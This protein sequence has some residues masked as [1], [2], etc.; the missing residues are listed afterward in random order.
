MECPKCTKKELKIVIYRSN[1]PIGYTSYPIFYYFRCDN[2]E[3]RTETER[4]SVEYE[5]Y[6]NKIRWN[7]FDPEKQKPEK[8]ES[9][10][11]KELM[12]LIILEGDFTK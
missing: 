10:Y 9:I 12:N 8:K 6:L 3:Y 11:L 2:C 4:M 5:E 1:E 7:L